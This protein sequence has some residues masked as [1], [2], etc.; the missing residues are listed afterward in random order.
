MNSRNSVDAKRGYRHAIDEFVD[1]YCSEPRLAFNRIV[2]IALILN[3]VNS[4]PAPAVQSRPHVGREAPRSLKLP[5]GFAYKATSGSD[6]Y[7][8]FPD[9]KKFLTNNMNTEETPAPLSLVLNWSAE[10]RK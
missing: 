6:S 10:L 7:D 3:P 9:G 1:W 2:V 8:A 4:P 5:R